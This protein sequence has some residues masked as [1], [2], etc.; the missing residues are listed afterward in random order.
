VPVRQQPERAELRPLDGERVGERL[1]ERHLRVR[2][3]RRRAR[4][5]ASWTNRRS[6]IDHPRR[7]PAA[8]SAEASTATWWSSARWA[9]AMRFAEVALS[10]P[11]PWPPSL[12]AQTEGDDLGGGSRRLARRIPRHGTQAPPRRGPRRGVLCYACCASMSSSPLDPRR[13]ACHAGARL[14]RVAGAPRALRRR[15]RPRARAGARSRHRDRPPRA[16]PARRHHRRAGCASVT[17]PWCTARASSSLAGPADRRCDLPHGGDLGASCA[18]RRLRD[19]RNGRSPPAW[20]QE[21]GALRGRSSPPA[22]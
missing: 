10:G 7:E 22:P 2:G 17:R 12:R 14:R 9:P 3:R 18:R 11:R 5:P 21:Q 19:E 13:L 8:R 4:P 20:I 16:G 6:S 15:P 1:D